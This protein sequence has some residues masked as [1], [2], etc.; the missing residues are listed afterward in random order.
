MDTFFVLC[1]V[2]REGL[3]LL[4][5]FLVCFWEIIWD[6]CKRMVQE[7]ICKPGVRLTSFGFSFPYDT[8]FFCI[9]GLF[10][11][12]TPLSSSLDWLKAFSQSHLMSKTWHNN[13][14]TMAQLRIPFSLSRQWYQVLPPL[15]IHCAPYSNF[16]FHAGNSAYQGLNDFFFKLE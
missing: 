11:S 2:E 16:I 4:G 7:D 12:N 8:P 9:Y 1:G 14:T 5:G 6:F 10:Y 15:R 13:T 3:V